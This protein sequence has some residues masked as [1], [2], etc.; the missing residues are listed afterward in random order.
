MKNVKTYSEFINENQLNEGKLGDLKAELH[1][2]TDPKK[3]KKLKMEIGKMFREK[4]PREQEKV[5]DN[6]LK[7]YRNQ[8]DYWKNDTDVFQEEPAKAKKPRTAWNKGD[9]QFGGW[10][11]AKYKRWIKDQA[12]H[13][14][15]ENAYDMARNSQFEPGLIDYVQAK[16]VYDEHP[17]ERIQW[18]IEMYS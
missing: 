12:A 14:G 3:A 8:I 5:G 7:T 2:E 16:E 6:H 15:A 10:T 13:G 4:S 11:K 9:K 18:D 1:K 17:L